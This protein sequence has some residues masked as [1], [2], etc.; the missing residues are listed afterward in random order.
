MLDTGANL[1]IV[2]EAVPDQHGIE[3]TGPGGSFLAADG[4]EVNILGCIE[5]VLQFND[6]FQIHLEKVAV[7]A[8]S[9]Y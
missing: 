3:I 8:G 5:L 1:S 2:T 7:Q 4:R 9:E 6:Y